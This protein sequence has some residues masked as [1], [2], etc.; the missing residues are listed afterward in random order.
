MQLFGIALLGLVVWFS[1]LELPPGPIKALDLHAL[2][3]VLGGSF[4][5][6]IT[7]SSARAAL[8]T[9]VC[10]RE[11]IPFA[12]SLHGTSQRLEQE[13][14]RFS[15]LWREG[16]RAQAVE[17]AE[18]SE[19]VPIR[20]MLELV[21]ARAP[22]EMTET[23]FLKLRHQEVSRWQ[24]A[25]SNWEGLAKLG[26]SFGLLGTVSGI[27]QL[28]GQMGND[29]FEI[30][31]SMSLALLSTLY[32]IVLGTGIAGPVGQYLRN[33]LDER[34]GALSRCRQSVVELAETRGH[35]PGGLELRG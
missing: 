2:V 28:F 25:T 15:Q 23:E 5:T 12:G 7:S 29:D 19:L 9:V 32:G 24:P 18:G 6:M 16:K 31:T 26:P 21:L 4:A 33:L 30:G 8:Q 1:F 27:V 20:K 34:L 14:E 10:I 35:E 22:R 3:I 11:L 17:L 13:R